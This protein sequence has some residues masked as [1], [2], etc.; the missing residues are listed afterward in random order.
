MYMVSKVS[1][2]FSDRIAC[3]LQ[4]HMP[5][6]RMQLLARVASS[7]RTLL[8]NEEW[9]RSCSGSSASSSCQRA[10]LQRQEGRKRQQKPKT[11]VLSRQCPQGGSDDTGPAK[12]R[13]DVFIAMINNRYN[14]QSA[15]ASAAVVTVFAPNVQVWVGA[16]HGWKL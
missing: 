8:E 16:R 1:S 10:M 3:S 11:E 6:A 12:T 4:L 9:P 5:S 2:S 14:N 15:R 13:Y 7:W